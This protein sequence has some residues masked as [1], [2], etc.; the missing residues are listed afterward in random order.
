MTR[1]SYRHMRL[2]ACAGLLGVAGCSA[3]PGGDGL[4]QLMPLRPL[5]DQ[6]D[7]LS[8]RDAAAGGQELNERAENL[9]TRATAL[10][11]LP[12]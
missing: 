8:A 10:R 2:L 7:A 5:A 1:F 4:P 11:D 9:R 6:R 12:L 3:V